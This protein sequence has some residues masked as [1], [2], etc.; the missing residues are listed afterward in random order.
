MIRRLLAEADAL[1]AGIITWRHD[2]GTWYC[3][4]SSAPVPHVARGVS[5]RHAL[6]KLVSFIREHA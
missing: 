3:F 2:E 6:S 4:A 5:G 1:G